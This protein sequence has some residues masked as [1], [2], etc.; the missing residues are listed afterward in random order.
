MPYNL[1]PGSKEKDTPGIFRENDKAAK[2]AE[3]AS[4]VESIR[5]KRQSVSEKQDA[6]LNKRRAAVIAKRKEIAKRRGTTYTY[7]PKKMSA[8][9][10]SHYSPSAQK[11]ED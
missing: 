1:D 10:G 9:G 7:K 3:R 6:A 4:K 2:L 5:Q 11:I 8:T